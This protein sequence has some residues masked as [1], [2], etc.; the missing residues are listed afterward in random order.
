MNY[1]DEQRE[2][3]YCVAKMLCKNGA[4]ENEAVHGY[5]EQLEAIDRATVLF[6]ENPNVV[7]VLQT[8]RAATEEKISDELNH[9]HSL[10]TEYENFMGIAPAQD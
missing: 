5:T 9:A 4:D 8:L 3:L 10:L 7:N 2:A 1:T 6:A